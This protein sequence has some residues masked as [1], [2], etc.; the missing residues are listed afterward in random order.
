[1]FM[2]MCCLICWEEFLLLFFSWR[3]TEKER[4]TTNKRNQSRAYVGGTLQA[5]QGQRLLAQGLI[6]TLCGA[7]WTKEAWHNDCDWNLVEGLNYTACSCWRQ[8]FQM[9]TSG[10]AFIKLDLWYTSA[11]WVRFEMTQTILCIFENVI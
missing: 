5:T 4:L 2:F 6:G 1:M 7:C 10:E 11:V 9:L 3:Q 8:D